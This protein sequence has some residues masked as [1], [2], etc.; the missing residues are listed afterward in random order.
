[1]LSL[2][3]AD[4]ALWTRGTPHGADLPVDGVFTDTRA[5]KPARCS[6][7]SG[8]AST[9][10]ISW[11]RRRPAAPRRRWSNARSQ[12]ACRRWSWPTR[13]SRS[14]ISPVRCARSIARALS[15]LPAPTARRPSRPF[16]PRSSAC[17]ARRIST[18]AISTTKSACRCRSSP[19]RGRDYAVIEMGAGKPGDIAYLAASR[20]RKSACQQHCAAHLERMGT[21]EGIAETKGALIHP[22]G[23]RRR[24][25][26]RR[27]RVRRNVRRDGG[28]RRIVRFWPDFHRRWR[29]EIVDPARMRLGARP[30]RARSI[31]HLAAVTMS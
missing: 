29:G 15:A 3:L 17:T 28:S 23:P 18:P 10:T 20:V 13:C 12:S 24:R 31:C 30:A 9:R 8:K 27:R 5:P 11:H 2:K 19:C 1:M 6:L 4:I 14:A 26:Q 22:A 21:L 25:D 16:S 7:R